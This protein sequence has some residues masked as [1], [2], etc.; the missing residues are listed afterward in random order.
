MSKTNRLQKHLIKQRY[1][2]SGSNIAK[3]IEIIK[4]LEE[5]LSK[6]YD[7][8]DTLFHQYYEVLKNE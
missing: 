2:E 6:E 1:N 5:R 8:N 3:L 7:R 4:K